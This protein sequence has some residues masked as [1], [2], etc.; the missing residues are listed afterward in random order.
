MKFLF[1]LSG[2]HEI[3]PLAELL[4]VLQAEGLNYKILKF[5]RAG[6]LAM[7]EINCRKTDFAG[8][9]A[10]TQKAVEVV[11]VGRKLEKI[12]EGVYPKIRNAKSFRVKCDSNTVERTLGA[13]LH[14]RGLKV[15]LTKPERT[16]CVFKLAGKFIAGFEIPIE[17]NFEERHPLKR[18]FFHPTSM[19][20]KTARMLVNLACMQKG[21]TLLDPFCGAGGILIEAGLLGLK[22]YGW[23]IDRV[24][25]E[26]CRKNVRHYARFP[27][28]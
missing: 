6:R 1:K 13:L 25:L 5:D 28:F 15:D 11:L 27:V 9:L 4:A 8:R 22:T 24:M 17:K 16:V 12:A 20:P 14:A 19:K 2:E 18:P 10:L 23:D 26:G 21:E 3:L 7:V